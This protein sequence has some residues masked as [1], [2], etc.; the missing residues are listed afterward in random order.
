MFVSQNK[1]IKEN[2]VC[3]AQPGEQENC[4]TTVVWATTTT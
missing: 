2:A 1:A 3:I 4:S